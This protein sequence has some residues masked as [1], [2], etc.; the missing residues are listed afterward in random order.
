[1]KAL[2]A[3]SYDIG[4]ADGLIGTSTRKAIQAEQKR[5]GLTPADGRAGRKILEAL[6]G[7]QP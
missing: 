2:L 3:R 5:L 1:Q 6:K 4:E 7:A